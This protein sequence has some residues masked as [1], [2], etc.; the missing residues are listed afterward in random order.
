MRESAA[1]P[2][3]R[4]DDDAPDPEQIRKDMER[5]ELIKQR[6]CEIRSRMT[7]PRLHSTWRRSSRA[8]G[9]ANRATA[10]VSI[11]PIA[12]APA[13]PASPQHTHTHAI[14]SR[15]EDRLKRIRDEGW[16]R[17]APVSETNKP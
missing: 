15:E 1:P 9:G 3:S 16:D 11:D 10:T 14:A 17:F 7:D 2:V 13:P 6:R 4:K 5:L 12:H 8:L